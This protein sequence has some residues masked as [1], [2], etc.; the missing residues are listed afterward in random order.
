MIMQH[1]ITNPAWKMLWVTGKKYENS[2]FTIYR[3]ICNFV[4][5]VKEIGHEK[6]IKNNSHGREKTMDG[7]IRRQPFA[8]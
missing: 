1:L 2:D 3:T 4:M 7:N 8:Q 5:S 6:N